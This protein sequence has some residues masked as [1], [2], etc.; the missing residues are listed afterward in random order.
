[1]PSAAL[2]RVLEQRRLPD[3]G[4]ADEREHA[5]AAVP[6]LRKQ[7]VDRQPL[8][9]AAEQHAPI[10]TSRAPLMRAAPARR[11]N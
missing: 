6:R 10:L 3:P 1:M 8:L 5:A 2:G 11:Q 9:V 7:A 4:L